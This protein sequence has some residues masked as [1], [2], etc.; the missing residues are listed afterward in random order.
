[1]SHRYLVLAKVR[2]KL[3]FFSLRSNADPKALKQAASR[4]L[5]ARYGRRPFE[6]VLTSTS[7]IA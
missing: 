7:K 6:F 1:M 2:E 4:M 5:K 3:E